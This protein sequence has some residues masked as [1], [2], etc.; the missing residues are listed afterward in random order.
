[1]LSQ[2]HQAQHYIPPYIPLRRHEM[3]GNFQ[4]S[5]LTVTQS[6]FRQPFS[7]THIIPCNT[8]PAPMVRNNGSVPVY[9]IGFEDE[10]IAAPLVFPILS[11]HDCS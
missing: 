3:L 7:M 11:P 6:C 4:D 1:M 10:A 9:L 2:I 5:R 8:V